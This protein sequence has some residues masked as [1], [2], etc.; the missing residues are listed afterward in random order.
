MSE[1]FRVFRIYA[2]LALTSAIGAAASAAPAH[3]GCWR[4]KIGGRIVC[5][6][7]LLRCERR[8][9]RLYH[10]Y[11]FTCRLAPDGSYRLRD[12]IFIAPPNP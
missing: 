8:Y 11:G 10:Y 2:A 4:A 3:P 1:I 9:E 12:R 6:Q 5:V 7:P